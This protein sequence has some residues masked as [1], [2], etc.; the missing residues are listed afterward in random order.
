MKFEGN[1][2]LVMYFATVK[3][4]SATYMYVELHLARKCRI[5]KATSRTEEIHSSHD[6][7]MHHLM[8]AILE[9][10]NE[11]KGVFN[12]LRKI[13]FNRYLGFVISVPLSISCQ[14]NFF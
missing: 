2:I 11:T 4:F 3:L 14:V 13:H 8:V 1:L 10:V 9:Y 6:H 12:Y 5:V 7:T